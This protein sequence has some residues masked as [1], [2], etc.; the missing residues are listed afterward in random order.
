MATESWP[1]LAC[2]TS[3]RDSLHKPIADDRAPE[4]TGEPISER[5]IHE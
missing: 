2:E 1:F 4:Q 5:E 3:E